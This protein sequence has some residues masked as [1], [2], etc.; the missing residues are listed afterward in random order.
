MF[1]YGVGLNSPLAGAITQQVYKKGKVR[2]KVIIFI[3]IV[4]NNVFLSNCYCGSQYI[5]E[6]S[7][8]I[9]RLPQLVN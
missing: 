7:L 3:S 5:R 9:D 4:C 2:N 1:K 8:Y 6:L